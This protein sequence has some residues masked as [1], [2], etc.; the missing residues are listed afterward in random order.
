M[1]I[2]LANLLVRSPLPRIHEQMETVTR[3]AAK[4][5][6]LVASLIDGDQASV[7]RIAKETS[8]LEGLCDDAKNMVRGKMPIRLFLPV[9]RRDVLRLVS[10]IDA[11]A[12]CAEDVGVLLTIRPMEMPEDMK[13]V[14]TLFVDRVMDVVASSET[15]VN[16]IE[17]LIESGFGG[18]PAERARTLIDEIARKEHEADKLQDQ[19]AKVLFGLEDDISPV[20]LFMWTK[21]LNK[22]GD[23]ANH[24][25][26]IGDQFRLFVAR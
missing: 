13:T 25:E 24:A 26:N 23:M 5:P 4:V 9:D 11:V 21:I 2:P 19:C 20:A 3:C 17:S 10:Q 6:E 15:L 8:M 14:L 18:R 16:T 22:I 1:R 12:D 7:E